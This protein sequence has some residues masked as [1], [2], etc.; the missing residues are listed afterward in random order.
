MSHL[1]AALQ[2]GRNRKESAALWGWGVGGSKYL[3]REGTLGEGGRGPGGGEDLGPALPIWDQG[4]NSWEVSPSPSG[5]A[6]S[7]HLADGKQT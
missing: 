5:Q 6:S 1:R 4:G 2:L 7:S 3:P